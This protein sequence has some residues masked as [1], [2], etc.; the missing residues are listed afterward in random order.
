MGI[1]SHITWRVIDP[2]MGVN[3]NRNAGLML[4]AYLTLFIIDA[5]VSVRTRS[6]SDPRLKWDA[7]F[8][9]PTSEVEHWVTQTCTWNGT[10]GWSDTRETWTFSDSHWMGHRVTQT[11]VERVYSG[12]RLK[13]PCFFEREVR[14]LVWN[15]TFALKRG[16]RLMTYP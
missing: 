6:Y 5:S 11:H 14:I 13:S 8:L 2:V 1:N 7:G 4:D 10:W 3:Y 16:S 9:R 15:M 12:P